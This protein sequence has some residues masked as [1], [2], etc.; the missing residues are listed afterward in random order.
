MIENLYIH[1]PFCRSKCTY[2]DFFSVAGRD[3][4]LVDSYVSALCSEIGF[5]IESL[6]IR[7]FE[8]VYIGG[9][10]PS[11]LSPLQIERLSSSFRA[12][13]DGSTEISIEANPDDITEDFLKGCAASGVNRLSLG[14]QAFSDDVLKNVRRRGNGGVN[15]RALSLVRERWNGEFS[16]DMICALPFQSEEN[17]LSGIRT[18]SL[19]S[20][21][22]ISM[23][24]LT[25]EEG[26]PLFK[27]LEASRFPYS[28]DEADAM[29]IRGRDLLE[30]L[31]YAQYE[32]SNFYRKDGGKRCLHNLCYWNSMPYAASGC[33]GTGSVYGKKA[34]RYT[35]TRD[36]DEYVRFWSENHLPEKNMGSVFSVL[37]IDDVEFL[38][39]ENLIFEYF[40]MGLR[41][42]GGVSLSDFSRR[43]GMALPSKIQD[44]VSR[45]TSRGLSERTVVSG[46]D[47]FFLN[48]E[49]L[50][51]L[52]RFLQEIA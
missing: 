7:R 10:T 1:V 45:W 52:N 13:C 2:C 6:G 19:F 36:I 34:Y 20:P 44:A 33:G 38:S 43:F 51:F 42:T 26:T 35:V 46:E 37:P 9:G 27:D 8:S 47:V 11:I 30:E 25:V 4:S 23:Y 29:W 14:V 15:V 28:F 32:V 48:R 22:H 31:G 49:G 18:L 5:R 24:S 40:M 3:G 50:L 16:A 21:S 39:T 17:F 41:K 12:L